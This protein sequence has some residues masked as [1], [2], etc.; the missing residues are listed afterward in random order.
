MDAAMTAAELAATAPGAAFLTDLLTLILAVLGTLATALVPVLV[1]WLHV[2][3]GLDKT[4]NAEKTK[5]LIEHVVKNAVLAA[6]ERAHTATGKT[7]GAA[8]LEHA[9]AVAGHLIEQY[10]LTGWAEDRIEDLIHAQVNHD[11]NGYITTEEEM[12]S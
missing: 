12:L 5:R 4:Q 6:E 3:T 2:K 8:K 1:R 10:G 9:R 11:R 7:L